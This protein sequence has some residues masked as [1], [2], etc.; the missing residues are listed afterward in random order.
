V[1]V[2]FPTTTTPELK[3]FVCEGKKKIFHS[4]SRGVPILVNTEKVVTISIDLSSRRLILQ[5]LFKIEFFF[6]SF[7]LIFHEGSHKQDRST[8]FSS[9]WKRK[10]NY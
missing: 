10:R 7:F 4:L 3:F 6:F 8:L 5:E 2:A 1:P 9:K